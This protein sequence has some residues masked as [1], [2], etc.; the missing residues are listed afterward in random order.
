MC[1]ENSP[2][3]QPKSPCVLHLEGGNDPVVGVVIPQNVV[4]FGLDPQNGSDGGQVRG[5]VEVYYRTNG[6]RTQPSISGR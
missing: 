2:M 6:Y 5:G 4:G 3:E 1:L